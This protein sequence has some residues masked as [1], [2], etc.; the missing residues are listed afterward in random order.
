MWDTK[1]QTDLPGYMITPS[2]HL[3]NSS[4]N[5]V[6]IQ[7]LRWMKTGTGTRIGIE[8]KY[9]SQTDPARLDLRTRHEL[10]GSLLEYERGLADRGM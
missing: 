5:A 1:K 10:K 6:R 7:V 8:H 9:L 4:P 3:A 2:C